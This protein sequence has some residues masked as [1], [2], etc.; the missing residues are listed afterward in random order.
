MEVGKGVEVG[1]IVGLGPEVDVPVGTR[2]G[3]GESDGFGVN[4]GVMVAVNTAV[5]VGVIVTILRVSGERVGKL[6]EVGVI[7]GVGDPLE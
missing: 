4:V 5:G 3:V 2:V 7:V 1:S 6:T